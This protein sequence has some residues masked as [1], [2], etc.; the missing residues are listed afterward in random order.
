MKSLV[1]DTVDD[2][3]VKCNEFVDTVKTAYINPN[4]KTNHWLTAV[5]LLAV[6]CLLLL[7]VIVVKYYMKRGLAIS[8]LLSYYHRG[9]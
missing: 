2:I 8:G 3:V 4:D 5:A 1:D 7:V 6:A 9:E